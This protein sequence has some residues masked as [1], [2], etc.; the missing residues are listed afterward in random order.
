MSIESRQENRAFDGGPLAPRRRTNVWV[1]TRFQPKGHTLH[2]D[3]RV[4]G[5]GALRR[6]APAK[7][8]KDRS[9]RLLQG[10]DCRA[11][12]VPRGGWH[13]ISHGGRCR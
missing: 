5:E 4:I 12:R 1:E 9:F 13:S 10:G 7:A 2:E 11:S 8:I 6:F 3:Q